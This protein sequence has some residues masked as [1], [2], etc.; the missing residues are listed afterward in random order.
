MNWDCFE[1]DV[2]AL[3]LSVKEQNRVNLALDVITLMQDLCTHSS[4]PVDV[5]AA[6][7]IFNFKTK[8]EAIAVASLFD[9]MF[10]DDH[11]CDVNE[12]TDGTYYVRYW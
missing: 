8:E 11:Y 3:Q 12:N 4:K 2:H 10:D 1:K 7:C 6:D 5:D 9:A